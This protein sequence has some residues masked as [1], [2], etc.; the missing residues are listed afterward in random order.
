MQ[1]KLETK[2]FENAQ[3]YFKTRN[4]KSAIIAL[5]NFKKDF[6]DSKFND[7]GMFLKILSQY[8][9]ASN[10]FQNLQED[11]F[12][13]LIDLYLDFVDEYPSSAYRIEAEKMY[14]ESLNI[15]SNFATQKK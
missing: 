14:L 4:Y 15:L 6:P 12:R 3:Q 11:R 8:N 9:I 1:V 13:D 2:N 10:S 7:Q 5:E